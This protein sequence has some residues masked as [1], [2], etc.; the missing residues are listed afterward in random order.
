MLL[1]AD[2]LTKR[3]GSLAAL[4]TSASAST[5]ARSWDPAEIDSAVELIRRVRARGM[6]IMLVEH[7][8]QA[9]A[10]LADRV[11]VLHHGE[12]IVEGPPEAVLAHEQVIGAYLGTRRRRT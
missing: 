8:M 5:R 6:T 2:G 3:Y 12:K 9:I 10:S 7:V 4:R 11:I 1:E